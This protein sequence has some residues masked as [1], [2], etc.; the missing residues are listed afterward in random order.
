MDSNCSNGTP[1]KMP[2]TVLLNFFS[3]S[4]GLL[5]AA[6]TAIPLR[7]YTTYRSLGLCAVPRGG[8][9]M[10]G[11]TRTGPLRMDILRPHKQVAYTAVPTR[12]KFA[13][14]PIGTSPSQ[15]AEKNSTSV[16]PQKDLAAAAVACIQECCEISRFRSA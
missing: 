8:C 7:S 10:D 14:H 13:S 6:S 1:Y 3:A 2:I 12:D 11:H 15:P 16:K 5:G 9:R 4:Y